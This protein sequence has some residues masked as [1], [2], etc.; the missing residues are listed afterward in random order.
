MTDL[1]EVKKFAGAGGGAKKGKTPTRTADN[2]FS[3]DTVEAVLALSEGPIRGLVDGMKS[4]NVGDTPLMT[5]DGSVMFDSFNLA[6]YSGK[7][8]DARVAYRFGG[9]ASNS[10]VG[11]RLRQG[12]AVSRTTDSTLRGQVDRLEIRLVFNTLY[13]QNDDGV[14][15]ETARFQIAYRP[16][17]QAGAWQYYQGSQETQVRGKTSSGYPKDFTIDVPR[18][19]DDWVVQI[20]KLNPEDN[21]FSF[22]DVTWESFQMITTQSRAYQNVA[23]LHI[24]AKAT[25]QFSSVP[26]FTGVYDGMLMKVPTTYNPDLHFH[27]EGSGPWNGTFK[28]DWTNNPAWILY[29][30]IT[31]PRWGFAKY[32]PT[33]TANKYDFYAAAKWCDELVPD[34]RGGTQPRYTYNEAITEKRNALEMLTYIAGAFNAVVFDD[35]SGAVHL[36][37][38]RWTEPTMLFTP[39]MV[40]NGE[41]QYTFTDISTRYND[42]TVTFVNPDLDWQDDIRG[43]IVDNPQIEKNGRIPLEFRAVGCTDEHEALRRAYY[44]LVTAC[45]EVATVNF[46]VPRSGILVDPYDII[47]VADPDA[48]WSTGGRIKSTQGDRIFLRDPLYMPTIK[49]FT[50]KIQTVEGLRTLTVQ[51]VV[52]GNVYELQIME[53][54]LF[55]ATVPDRTTFTIEENGSF[56]Y[57]KPFRVLS[58]QEVEGSPNAYT[59]SALEINVNKYAAADNCQ[60]VGSVQYSF[61]NPKVPPSPLNLGLESGTKHLQIGQDGVINARIYAEWQ[62]PTGVMIDHYE[63]SYRASADDNWISAPDAY[64]ESAYLTP[65]QT[66]VQ[67][68]VMIEAVN[69]LGFRSLPTVIFGHTVVGKTE[70]PSDVTN[71]RITRRPTDLLLQWDPITDLDAFGY[72]LRQGPSWDLG[73]I[74]TTDLSA[75]AFVHDQS[76]KGVYPYHIRA[77]DTSGNYSRNVTTFVLELVA[78]EPV[79]GFFAVPSGS[80]L[81][82]HWKPNAEKNIAGYE[83]REG[84]TWGIA[85][86]IAQVT[87][88]SY[89][90]PSGSFGTRM[91]WIKAIAAP[92]IYSDVAV[93]TNNE[94][95]EPTDTNV[96]FYSDQKAEGFPGIRHNMKVFG[97]SDL[98]ME[99][100]A[101]RSEYLFQ[102]SLPDTYR[103]RNTVIFNMEA[104]R[105]L[106]YT[107]E[108]ASFSWDSL[109]AQVPWAYE[110]DLDS[111]SAEIQMAQRVGLVP[112]RGDV[113]GWRLSGNLNSLTSNSSLEFS[114]HVTYSPDGRYGQG[115][116]VGDFTQASWLTTLPAQFHFSFWIRPKLICDTVYLRLIGKYGPEELRVAYYTSSKAFVLEDTTGQV[117][118]VPYDLQE[119]TPTC[120]GV[121]QRAASR[122]LFIASMDLNSTG[123]GTKNYIPLATFGKVRIY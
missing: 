88:T 69:A 58:I 19:N 103:A 31:N 62:A 108:D 14:F 12:A 38:D 50:M 41:F 99:D 45:T 17:A 110:G 53:G 25:S 8:N 2:L 114:S 60:P 83:I 123:Q 66:G 5:E 61:K 10:P 54:N 37:V 118:E 36:R 71:F 116:M 68:D 81:E 59:V 120:I 55:G 26:A 43:G 3:T 49:N 119:D 9:E 95:A 74:L 104:R 98:T 106:P 102:V 75:T 42:V 4:F 111:L 39:E 52:S 44:R 65:V 63:V 64:G 122:S 80:R 85:Q 87:A 115:A 29:N 91:F 79:Q 13:L 101:R 76:E 27:D 16:A 78:P 56:G 57:A 109:Q 33:I 7:D 24:V 72:E 32:Y 86:F 20:T 46:K 93:F 48:G 113:E 90:I 21:T 51:P 105:D 94:I 67:Y 84:S 121:V 23:L 15:E 35:A 22:C 112:S 82:F 34:G 28:E 70:P 77:I 73:T 96:V 92:G 97:T 89:S 1:S 117:I 40:E 107:W 18:I 100:G 30:L 11:V 6:V 47:Y